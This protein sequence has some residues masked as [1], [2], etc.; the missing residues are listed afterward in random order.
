MAEIN[1]SNARCRL[2][3]VATDEA[4]AIV[5]EDGNGRLG[6]FVASG[7]DLTGDGYDDVVMGAPVGGDHD[8]GA[9]W[10]QSGPL[11]TSR[12]TAAVTVSLEATTSGDGLGTSASFGDLDGDGVDDLVVGVPYSDLATTNAGAAFVMFGPVTGEQTPSDTI[13]WLGVSNNE[14]AGIDVAVVGDLSGDGLDDLVVG[15]SR[16]TTDATRQGAAFVVTGPASAGGSLSDAWAIVFGDTASDNLGS[17]L[18]PAGDVDED[19]LV[20]LLIAAEGAD[21]QASNEGAVYVMAGLVSGVSQAGDAYTV[22]NGGGPSSHTGRALRGGLD[23]DGDD[24]P[25]FLVGAPQAG[26]G[27]VASLLWRDDY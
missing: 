4:L 23:L 24:L 22:L 15:A 17:K 5:G 26:S 21:G 20:D 10:V 8:G 14:Y 18:A 3:V 12:Y 9:I 1:D 25:D 27:G 6:S 16:H 13:S 7:G 19:G 2:L 11:S